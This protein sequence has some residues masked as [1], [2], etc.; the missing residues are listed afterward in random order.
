MATLDVET[1]EACFYV[2]KR[3]GK[4]IEGPGVRLAE[5]VASCWGNL[6]V[7]GRII[8]DDGRFVVAQGTCWDVERNV[9]IRTEVQR[10]VTT[11]NGQRYSDD[12]IAVTGN[13]AMS[14]ALRNA[15]FRVVPSAY[16]HAIY[17]AA[18]RVAVGDERTLVDRRSKAFAWFTKAGVETAKVLEHLGRASV[19][20]V[21]L[22]DLGVLQGLRTAI[23]E[24]ST[25][26]DQVFAP[27]AAPATEA[28]KK[29]MAALN[30]ATQKLD[31]AKQPEATPE[32]EQVK[33]DAA[34]VCPVCSVHEPKLR[35]LMTIADG[36][37]SCKGVKP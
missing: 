34:E 2:L 19:E 3:D 25:T 10:R 8:A 22:D 31:E 13:A 21:K 16:T 7:E 1:A 15:I 26:I 28:P 27:K 33:L 23:Q 12:M 30:K 9:V 20:D 24:G 17:E 11:K 32:P 18:R 5:I 29:G 4:S 36:C 37:P 6:R 14:I 35:G